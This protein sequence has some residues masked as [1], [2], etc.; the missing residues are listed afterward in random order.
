MAQK[1]G[2]A[3]TGKGIKKGSLNK[4][5]RKESQESL[6]ETEKNLTKVI[7]TENQKTNQ[8]KEKTNEIEDSK[9]N[10]NKMNVNESTKCETQT[11]IKNIP[12]DERSESSKNKLK[13]LVNKNANMTQSNIANKVY[14]S[15]QNININENKTENSILKYSQTNQTHH[16]QVIF[17]QLFF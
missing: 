9:M 8:S 12:C 1:N 13:K 14:E 5:V 11:D 2:S 17:I 3:N 4:S 7:Q 15:D 10:K 6:L 16:L